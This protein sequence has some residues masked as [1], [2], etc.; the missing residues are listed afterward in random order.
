MSTP[1]QALAAAQARLQA[2]QAQLQQAQAE[3]VRLVE[4]HISWVLLAATEAYKLKKPLRLPFLDWTTLAARRASCEEELRLNRR[5]A[6]Q[7]YLGLAEVRTGAQGVVFGGPGELL[8]VAVRMR[9]FPDGALWC[10]R[11]AAGSLLP[12]HVDAMARRLAA[13][14]RTAAVAP[15]DGT[16][17]GPAAHQH[18]LLGLLDAMDRWH[19]S[20]ARNTPPC[21]EWPSLRGWL[22]AEQTRLAPHAAERLRGGFVR[23]GHGD[24]H[25]ANL[26]VLDGEPC[27]FDGIDFDPA[28]RWID[29]L[30]DLAFTTMDLLAHGA[31]ALA[32][33]FLDAWLAETGDHAGLPALRLQLV[34]RALVRAQVMDLSAGV[35][36]RS[37]GG[38]SADDY[39]RLAQRLARGADPRLAITHGL[40]G[41][42]KSTAAM[43]LVERAGA[44]RLRSDVERK[45]LAGLAPLDV[46]AGR[47]PGLYSTEFTAAT[48]R[49]LQ[50]LARAG[51][52]AGWPVVVDAAFLRRGERAAF[53]ALADEGNCPFA[54]V[55]CQAP[56]AVLHDRVAQRRQQGGDASE[57][58]GAVL[59]H[60][61][62]VAEPLGADE[63]SVALVVD[64]ADP[65]DL[66][67][68]PARWLAQRRGG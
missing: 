33:R 45:R 48:Y 25:L 29:V 34:R 8:D 35:P 38:P 26:L 55:D 22:L 66:D 24:L 5:L 41:S 10:D 15:V 58:D 27:A 50:V 67:S 49:R 30:D 6:P 68:L 20:P 47:A 23:E 54:I 52:A 56:L 11:L 36:A 57:A 21:I 42:G 64:A 18:I 2:L 60:L 4:T 61:H 28:L 44:L 14:Q 63:R 59:D 1:E 9:R 65:V 7:I 13:F 31:D 19:A 51:L 46:S 12:N 43:R 16:W 37:P 3:P 62:T 39:R 40:P 53:A 32:W 17:T